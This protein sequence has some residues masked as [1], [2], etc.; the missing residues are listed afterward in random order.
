MFEEKEYRDEYQNDPTHPAQH[1]E[2]LMAASP[3]VCR[4]KVLQDRITS[5]SVKAGNTWE[6][7]VLCFRW[8][9]KMK[10]LAKNSG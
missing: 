5:G 7:L 3:S 8:E 2:L 10:Q 4:P 6:F 9:S 1:P